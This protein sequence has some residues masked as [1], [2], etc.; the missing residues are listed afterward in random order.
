MRYHVYVHCYIPHIP[1]L[2]QGITP[3]LPH[4]VDEVCSALARSSN[5]HLM[6][7]HIVS[8]RLAGK[9]RSFDYYSS[10]QDTNST[11]VT[12]SAK[13]KRKVPTTA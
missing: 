6:M 7:Q 9:R 12:N 1:Q 2:L 11:A 8:D 3:Q 4:N 10:K 13:Q 5:A